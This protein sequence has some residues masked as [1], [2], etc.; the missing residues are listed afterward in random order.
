MEEFK[1]PYIP[2]ELIRQQDTLAKSIDLNYE[3]PEFSSKPIHHYSFEVL[4]TGTILE[5]TPTFSK[6]FSTI[7]RLPICDISLG[8]VLLFDLNSTHGT[9]VNKT[10]IE[11]RKYVKIK[12]GDMIK[13][14]ES[15]RLYILKGGPLE[16]FEEKVP[17][18]KTNVSKRK[19]K[20][21][22]FSWGF[23]PDA[24]EELEE[25][26]DLDN[27]TAY[28]KRDP[29]KA[30]RNW[31]DQRGQEIIV[32]FS[33]EG[34]KTKTYAAKLVLEVNSGEEEFFGTSHK[35][36]EAEVLAY[37]EACTKLDRLGLLRGDNNK[38][39]QRIKGN[40]DDELDSFYDRTKKS[41]I[42]D[43][44]D[45]GAVQNYDSLMKN[46]EE[47]LKEL[48][49]ISTNLNE[50]HNNS[51]IIEDDEEDELEKFMQKQSK[52]LLQSNI[53]SCNKRKQELELQLEKV[54]LLLKVVGGPLEFAKP[55]LASSAQSNAKLVIEKPPARSLIES[56]VK[57]KKNANNSLQDYL[58]RYNKNEEY[59]HSNSIEEK[60]TI[61]H[62][63]N[64]S[65]R[66]SPEHPDAQE[67]NDL[68]E[69]E[70]KDLKRKRIFNVPT[71]EV[72]QEQ[73]QIEGGEIVD[74]WI[75][76]NGSTTEDIKLL[77]EKYGY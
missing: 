63:T 76:P 24:E 39:G 14:G 60:T 75:P 15:T 44:Q 6:N 55:S 32:Q 21:E 46:K 33:E 72:S 40:S 19:I 11:P 29:K 67:D 41:K 42:K 68:N 51:K 37:L 2:T 56:P 4:K 53:D 13:F 70:K 20:E 10:R 18:T 36:K 50:L 52:E 73:L 47:I 64:D 31:A 59:K 30:L 26:E 45:D 69:T 7:G 74:D 62:S 49:D 1:L 17:I 35:K 61:Y 8:E 65:K 3:E 9:F 28:Y 34:T 77:N 23:K 54:L 38:T 43:K 66:K 16:N 58:N 25:R 48:A 5:E 71:A 12:A 57:K 27:D 22:E